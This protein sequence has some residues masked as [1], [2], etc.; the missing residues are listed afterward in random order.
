M[1]LSL[2][3][4]HYSSRVEHSAWNYHDV[5]STIEDKRPSEMHDSEVHGNELYRSEIGDWE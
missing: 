2:S 1:R 4:N 3:C 5:K